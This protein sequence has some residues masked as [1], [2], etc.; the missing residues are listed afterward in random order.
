MP[1][2]R[3]NLKKYVKRICVCLFT[4]NFN[5]FVN[6]FYFAI[7]FLQYFQFFVLI[8]SEFTLDGI[9]II[10]TNIISFYIDLGCAIR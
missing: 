3:I 9:Y 4:V 6:D 5:I 7:F 1:F 8:V 2:V 10:F